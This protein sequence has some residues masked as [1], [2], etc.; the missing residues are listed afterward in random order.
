MSISINSLT[1]TGRVGAVFGI[2]KY[3]SGSVL[4]FTVAVRPNFKNKNGEYDTQWY[5]CKVWDKPESSYINMLSSQLVKGGAVTCI[6]QLEF[7]PATGGPRLFTGTDGVWK[8]VF[9]VNCKDVVVQSPKQQNSDPGI[10]SKSGAKTDKPDR[11]SYSDM[12]DIPW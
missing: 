12:D 7:D 9:S 8:A 1:F 4:E 6:G 2:K 11:D 5:F 10:P 3:N